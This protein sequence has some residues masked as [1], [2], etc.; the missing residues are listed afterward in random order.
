VGVAKKS[1]YLCQGSID[2]GPLGGKLTGEARITSRD[3]QSVPEL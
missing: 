2:V 3:W 1:D